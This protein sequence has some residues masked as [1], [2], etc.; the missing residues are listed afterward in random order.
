MLIEVPG[1]SP[2]IPKV[3][4]LTNPPSANAGITLEN[5]LPTILPAPAAKAKL[6]EEFKGG[7][8]KLKAKD[9]YR[10][11]MQVVDDLQ[12]RKDHNALIAK[13]KQRW[14]DMGVNINFDGGVPGD[15]SILDKTDNFV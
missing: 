10:I 1:P 13:V 8:R 9:F 12:I 7:K 11:F 15:F 4:P 2:T 5:K 3:A 14:K 6:I